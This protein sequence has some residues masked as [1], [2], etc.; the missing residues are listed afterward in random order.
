MSYLDKY[1]KYKTKYIQLKELMG[2][3]TPPISDETKKELAKRNKEKEKSEGTFKTL[4]QKHND[5][6]ERIV[7]VNSLRRPTYFTMEK[8]IS[9]I[10]DCIKFKLGSISDFS[11][12][13]LTYEYDYIKERYEYNIS[14]LINDI[15]AVCE[16]FIHPKNNDDPY[17]ID[18]L[19]STKFKDEVH[20]YFEN[21]VK[22]PA[23]NRL[24][25]EKEKLTKKGKTYDINCKGYEKKD[26]LT[27][28]CYNYKKEDDYI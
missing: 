2:G 7:V 24:N 15:N 12:H 9:M 22:K 26:D 27:P 1:L 4:A 23:V 16:M 3:V 18:L 6:V 13:E 20:N 11:R 19:I 10:K 14:K 5:Q 8:S 17:I 21:H 28:I 25:I